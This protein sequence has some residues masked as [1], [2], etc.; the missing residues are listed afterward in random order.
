[1]SERWCGHACKGG[2][3][4][5]GNTSGV[6]CV[7]GG[8]G[9]YVLQL[10]TGAVRTFYTRLFSSCRARTLDNRARSGILFTVGGGGY[11]ADIRLV[12]ARG[13]KYLYLL[14]DNC[15]GG[16][17]GFGTRFNGFVHYPVRLRIAERNKPVWNSHGVCNLSCG[18][19]NAFR[20]QYRVE[21]RGRGAVLFL[22]CDDGG[23]VGCVNARSISFSLCRRK[24]KT[25]KI[26]RA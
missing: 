13:H 17:F 6:A 4:Y 12:S 8:K 26:I 24:A 14:A 1:M 15:G 9:T 5:R 18:N 25:Q 22:A 2:K 7:Y 11:Y 3:V 21:R 20:R 19:N 23:A 10:R 16:L